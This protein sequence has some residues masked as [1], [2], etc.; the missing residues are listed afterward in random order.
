MVAGVDHNFASDLRYL[1]GHGCD[2]WDQHS[3]ALTARPFAGGA[4]WH[5]RSNADYAIAPE[6]EQFFR[7]HG[8]TTDLNV[9]LIGLTAD[10]TFG[11]GALMEA[12]RR[13]AHGLIQAERY[14]RT[15]GLWTTE[16]LGLGNRERQSS[17]G[18]P[19]QTW[20][21]VHAG[22]WARYDA[23]DFGEAGGQKL[24]VVARAQVLANFSATVHFQ[25]DSPDASGRV[26]A[27][28]V[29]HGSAMA[30]SASRDGFRV[31]NGTAGSVVAPSGVSSVFMVFGAV[32][33]ASA[34]TSTTDG[35]IGAVIDWFSF[36]M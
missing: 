29:I 20:D 8:F 4:P 7:Q 6:S 34:P 13:D 19:T 12:K 24:R 22:S 33:P 36:S 25:I 23:V 21:G 16:A 17:V 2:E 26:L 9:S 35:G 15:K 11:P 3:V 30:T 18:A 27:T 10:F 14:D 1:M 31:F 5:S 32:A 28:V